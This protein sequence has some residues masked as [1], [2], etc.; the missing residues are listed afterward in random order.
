MA[1]DLT[2]ASDRERFEKADAVPG[3]KLGLAAHLLSAL[4]LF[5]P[6]SN[7]IVGKA[8]FYIARAG[9]R[10]EE[11]TFYVLFG[12]AVLIPAA[13]FMLHPRGTKRAIFDTGGFFLPI[14]LWFVA[15]TQAS[16]ANYDTDGVVTNYLGGYVSAFLVYLAVRRHD[17]TRAE[18][19]YAFVALALGSAVPM[20]LGLYAF[21]LEW[22]SFDLDTVFS[23]YVDPTRWDEYCELTFGHRQNTGVF[24]MLIGN[25]LLALALDR[26]RPWMLRAWFAGV[27]ILFVA[28]LLVIQVRTATVLFGVAC[29]L[30]A[31][32]YSWHLA[33]DNALFVL[34]RVALPI[35]MLGVLA[36]GV[37]KVFFESESAALESMLERIG[38]AM[39]IDTEQDEATAERAAAIDEGWQMFIDNWLSGVGP[40]ASVLRHSLNSAHQFNVAQAVELG[41]LGFIAS[42]L[43]VASVLWRTAEATVHSF[44][45]VGDKDDMICLIGPA[46]YMIY[47]VLANLALNYTCVNVW[48]CVFAGFLALA[49]ARRAAANRPGLPLE[50]R[51]SAEGL[52]HGRVQLSIDA[53]E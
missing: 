41:V 21:Y 3:E 37:D 10:P 49:D 46:F 8:Y 20:L 28:N 51:R 5:L 25:P 48:I 33:R 29:V 42:I 23:A 50:T 4:F 44:A 40:S 2:I 24:I 22:G 32:W 34:R 30:L 15:A 52:S 7:T 36:Y 12:P 43:L 53:R 18:L 9:A 47:G 6:L 38:Y 1:I 27:S 17:W 26:T 39:T 45:A 35:L 16:I 31:V 13:L 11:V 19:D 14:F